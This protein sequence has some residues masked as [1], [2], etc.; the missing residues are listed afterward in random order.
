MPLQALQDCNIPPYVYNTIDYFIYFLLF[1]Y[2]DGNVAIQ[3]YDGSSVMAP[4]N[5]SDMY[6]S[7]IHPF[8]RTVIYGAIWFQ[9]N[10]QN[11]YIFYIYS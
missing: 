7:M 11:F 4:F 9:G 5:Y 6:N 2:R 3:P 8:M 10:Q 1:L